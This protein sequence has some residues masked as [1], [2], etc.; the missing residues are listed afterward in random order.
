MSAHRKYLA[1]ARAAFWHRLSERAAL[2]GRIVFYCLILLVFSC[3]WRTVFAV[4]SAG[5]T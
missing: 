3:V 4:R 5:A 1:I 2:I